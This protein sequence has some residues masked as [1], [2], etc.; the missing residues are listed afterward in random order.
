MKQLHWLL[1]GLCSLILLIGCD[2]A[3]SI[4][5]NKRETEPPKG[6]GATKE[7]CTVIRNYAPFSITGRIQLKSRERTNFRL[8]K[9]KVRKFASKECYT[10]EIQFHFY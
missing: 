10:V 6:E 1:I 4:Y 8:R 3:E 7:I 9:T 2:E 5:L